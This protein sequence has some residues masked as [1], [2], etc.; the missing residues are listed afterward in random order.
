[1]EGTGFDTLAFGDSRRTVEAKLAKSGRVS[2]SL[3]QRFRGR[4]GLNGV[5]QT[6]IQGDR[7]LL[8]FDWTGEDA[9]REVT[10]RSGAVPASEYGS[11]LQ[12]KWT[13]LAALLRKLHGNPVQQ[14]SFPAQDDLEDG[15][16]VGSHLWHIGKRHSILLST[17]LEKS[18]YVVAI[19]FTTGL[20]P[21]NQLL[22]RDPKSPDP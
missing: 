9:L 14:T 21:P 16:L 10:L 11:A 18:G 8:F 15:R 13:A 6:T 5:Y 22:V 3:D 4:T 19:R 20:I 2:A 12:G 1:L 17:G 7:Y